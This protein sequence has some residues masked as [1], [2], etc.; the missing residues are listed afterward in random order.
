MFLATKMEQL[1]VSRQTHLLVHAS[2][3]RNKTHKLDNYSNLNTFLNIFRGIKTARILKVN[4][5]GTEIVYFFLKN[6]KILPSTQKSLY[7]LHYL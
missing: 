3:K 1:S 5:S 7:F 6:A 2:R 4:E